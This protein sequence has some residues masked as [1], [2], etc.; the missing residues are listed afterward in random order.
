[1]RRGLLAVALLLP[2]LAHADG[3]ATPV[4]FARRPLVLQPG[5]LDLGLDLGVPSGPDATGKDAVGN[6]VGANL[7]FGYGAID[8]L[9]VGVYLPLALVKPTFTTG[10]RGAFGGIEAEVRYGLLAEPDDPLWL[11]VHLTVGELHPLSLSLV[12]DRFQIPDF[13]GDVHPAIGLAAEL[14]T[15]LFDDHV[16]LWADPRLYIHG[17]TTSTGDTFVA[18]DAPVIVGFQVLPQLFT[19]LRSA[20]NTG[21]HLELSTSDGLDIPLV[22]GAVY[23]MLGNHLDVGFDLGWGN[24]APRTGRTL[25]DT[26]LVGTWIAWRSK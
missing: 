13:A 8:K 7:R 9:S 4:E 16:M 15:T 19:G 20:L 25:N 26:L 10:T 17:D 23:T 11:A 21:Q 6:W 18:I 2:S 3:D 1:M 22:A 24:V 12:D 14:K 5:R